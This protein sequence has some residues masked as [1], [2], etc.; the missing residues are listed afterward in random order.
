MREELREKL[1]TMVRLGWD[2]MQAIREV[3][4]AWDADLDDLKA[5][6]AFFSGV[7]CER[8]RQK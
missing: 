8:E 7:E 1:E 6:E 2:K 3:R 4:Y 5:A